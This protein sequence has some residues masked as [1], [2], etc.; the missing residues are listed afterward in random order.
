MTATS[1]EIPRDQWIRFL[2]RFAREHQ[3]WSVRVE[4]LDLELGAQV[5]VSG[6]P[7][8]GMSADDRGSEH[9]ISITVGDARNPVLTHMI[10]GAQRLWVQSSGRGADAALEI[11]SSDGSRTLVRLQAA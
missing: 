3:G 1:Q 9:D 8:Q 11:E 5:E 7:L 4:V 10:P 6:L 2:D